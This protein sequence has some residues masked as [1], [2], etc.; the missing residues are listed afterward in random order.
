MAPVA[1]SNLYQTNPQDMGW[2]TEQ[3]EEID[4]RK[5]VT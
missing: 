4:H 5:Q 3:M 2:S 1:K